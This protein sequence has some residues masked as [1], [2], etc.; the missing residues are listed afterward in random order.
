MIVF[1]SPST[2]NSCAN[3]AGHTPGSTASSTGAAAGNVLEAPIVAPFNQCG[4]A[5]LPALPLN[6]LGVG[7]VVSVLDDGLEWTH[8]DI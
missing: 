8:A 7:V 3:A 5:D 6:D 1:D 4:G 2:D